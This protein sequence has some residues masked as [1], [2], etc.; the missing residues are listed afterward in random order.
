MK[1]NLRTK[2]ASENCP[3]LA[4]SLFFMGKIIKFWEKFIWGMFE[5]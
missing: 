1:T 3:T 2:G 4:Y 5:T